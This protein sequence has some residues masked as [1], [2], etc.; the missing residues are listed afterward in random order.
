MNHL[1]EIAHDLT[2]EIFE[3]VG[4]LKAI[5]GELGS[6]TTIQADNGKIHV[7]I[8]DKKI[9]FRIEMDEEKK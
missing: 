2:A 8:A 4:R 3:L 7:T 1:E 6:S 9:N 5:V